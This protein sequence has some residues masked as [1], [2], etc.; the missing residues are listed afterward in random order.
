MDW[1][2]L[3]LA[4]AVTGLACFEWGWQSAVKYLD[5][6]RAQREDAEK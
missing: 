6:A 2:F 3:L 1:P 4:C 5:R